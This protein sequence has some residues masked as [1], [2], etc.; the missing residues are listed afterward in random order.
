MVGKNWLIQVSAVA[1]GIA[2][3]ISFAGTLKLI[4]FTIGVEFLF[5]GIAVAT[6]TW[7]M[8]NTYLLEQQIHSADQTVEWL[9]CFDGIEKMLILSTL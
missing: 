8:T 2:Y 9:Y 7:Y 5:C 6:L 3:G 4:F 1:Y